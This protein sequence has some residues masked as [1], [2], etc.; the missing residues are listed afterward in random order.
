M[1]QNPVGEPAATAA[2]SFW[3]ATTAQFFEAIAPVRKRPV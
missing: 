2:L 1:R 3:H